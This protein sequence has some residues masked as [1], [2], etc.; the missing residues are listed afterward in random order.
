MIK[1]SDNVA[2]GEGSHP[3][4]EYLTFG[5]D[6]LEACRD[7]NFRTACSYA[8]NYEALAQLIGGEFGQVAGR[9]VFAPSNRGFDESIEKLEFNIDKA[10]QILDDARLQ[11]R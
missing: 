8:I 10:N 3:G 2:L 4:N 6:R 1:S 9:G 7:V 11:R 5:L